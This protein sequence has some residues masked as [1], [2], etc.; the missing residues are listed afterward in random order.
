MPAGEVVVKPAVGAGSVG[1]QRFTDPSAAREH[2][3]ALHDAGSTVLVQPYDARV[4][5]GETA[6]VFLAGE[7]SHA[8][9]KGPMLPARRPAAG[10]R[11]RPA[12]TRR[13]R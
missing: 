11:P 2:A 5:G 4:E 6:L 9:T 10:L 7:Q 3:A 8:F 13:S 1:A 12:R